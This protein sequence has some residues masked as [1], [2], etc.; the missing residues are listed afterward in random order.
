MA[1]NNRRRLKIVKKIEIYLF[2]KQ[3]W[4]S[5]GLNKKKSSGMT[6]SRIKRNDMSGLATLLKQLNIVSYQPFLPQVKRIPFPFTSVNQFEASVRAPV[7]KTWNPETAYRKLIEPKVITKMGTV[8]EPMDKAQVFKKQGGQL[9]DNKKQ[10]PQGKKLKK[11]G[12]Q[13]KKRKAKSWC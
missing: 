12:N 13:Q 11:G 7:G 6:M 4:D 9:P 2:S 3:V 8:I 1:K 10:E 5:E